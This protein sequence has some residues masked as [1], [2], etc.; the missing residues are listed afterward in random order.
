MWEIIPYRTQQAHVKH[1]PESCPAPA[2]RA[3]T[4]PERRRACQVRQHPLAGLSTGSIASSSSVTK[5]TP[6]SRKSACSRNADQ[7]ASTSTNVIAGGN[8]MQVEQHGLFSN[9]GGSL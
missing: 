5:R 9:L 7:Y 1:V 6:R 8:T 2:H 4:A 3:A